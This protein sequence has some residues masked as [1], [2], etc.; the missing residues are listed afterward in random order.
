MFW[1]FRKKAPETPPDRPRVAVPRPSAPGVPR[2]APDAPTG[3][4]RGVK[5]ERAQPPVLKLEVGAPS[6]PI[7]D[8]GDLSPATLRRPTLDLKFSDSPTPIPTS[9][10]KPRPVPAPRSASDFT[11]SRPVPELVEQ[12]TDLPKI[13]R[14]LTHGEDAVYKIESAMGAHI[15]AIDLGG[16]EAAIVR[17][18]GLPESV[19][20]EVEQLAN[21]IS[22]ALRGSSF[23][24]QPRQYLV[25]PQVMK[26][27]RRLFAA[28]NRRAYT[29]RAIELFRRWIELAVKA[30]A[31][32]IHIEIKGQVA[33]VKVRVD[34][35]L[36]PLVDGNNPGLYSAKDALDA[37][38]AG[39]NDAR[40]GNN[41]AHYEAEKF[42]NCMVGF[43]VPGA[44]GQ[45]RYQNFKG[46]L[47]PKVVI[48]ILRS[49][50]EKKMTLETAGYAPSHLRL[51]KLAGRAGNGLLL[52]TG[53]VG[54][55]KS[56]TQACFMETLPGREGKAL[57]TIEDPIEIEIEGTHQMEINRDL[58]DAELTDF[59]YGEVQKALLRG[60]LDAA[61]VGE[62]RD[63]ITA[64]FSLMIAETGHLALGT[65]HA[66]MI[67]NI[68]PRLTNPLVGLSRDSLTGPQIINM[69]VYQYL[70][71]LLCQIC[72]DAPEEAVAL[73]PEIDEYLTILR[74][75]FRVPTT[76][77][78]FK[79]FGGCAHCSYRGTKGKSVVAE[80]WQPD[81][82]WSELV[83]AND[84]MGAH[85]HYR[86][87][88]N[89]DFT[90]EDMTG[91]TIFEHT[92]W[93]ALQG[94]VDVRNCE[95][96]ETF[97]RFEVLNED[98]SPRRPLASVS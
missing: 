11:N 67:S 33:H 5:I 39:Y 57:Y 4:S 66:H 61:S 42:V 35:L 13:N 9:T 3:Q 81:R 10:P 50:V 6:L 48:R 40:K 41:N 25:V 58:T 90:S 74:T 45:L 51:W 28:T 78:R 84:D 53:K 75:K 97:E 18:S 77:L 59:R 65:L 19:E 76:G 37:M 1:P 22:G 49:Q 80:M 43:D 68:V 71:P 72:C 73:D 56:T 88:S 85:M 64:S 87:Q 7:G 70:V 89:G 98:P 92:L 15:A 12:F 96:F 27:V 46:R 14:L 32:D 95:E 23:R 29:S 36:E 44:T 55:G 62:I 31:T 79:H 21:S 52:I 60:D 82:R 63:Q 20:A 16:L 38:A 69:L 54:S 83:R 86:A 47:G 93:K 2:P 30:D 8:S 94:I 34:S 24:V 91:K 26:E 17:V